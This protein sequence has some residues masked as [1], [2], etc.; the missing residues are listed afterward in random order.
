[1]SEEKKDLVEKSKSDDEKAFDLIQRKARLYTS[2]ELVP[3]IYRGATPGAL[4]NCVI[5]LEIANRIGANE[6]MV[7][8]NL[9]VINGRPSWSS[10][11][12]ISALNSCGRFSPIR[13]E[14]RSLGNTICNGKS[15][16]NRECKAI[17]LDLDTRQTLEGPPVTIAMAI[18]EG[19]YGKNGSKWQTMPELML[20]Y[21]AAAFFGRLYAPELLNGLGTV[22]ESEDIAA[23]RTLVPEDH[24]NLS[25]T[26]KDKS[27]DDFSLEHPTPDPVTADILW[28]EL[29]PLLKEPSLPIA[30]KE[31][32]REANAN[33]ERDV[34]KLTALL[35]KA[36]RTIA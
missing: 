31:E 5:A 8:Q 2:S 14:L 32:I 34:E 1:M 3:T 24:V 4:A 11:F 23:G 29:A 33:E 25:A 28:E 35:E 6:L 19:W 20:R 30:A 17:A 13:F 16:D 15:L 18:A 26:P 10:Q 22:E 36:R 9:Y 27:D 7:M 12:I 21:R